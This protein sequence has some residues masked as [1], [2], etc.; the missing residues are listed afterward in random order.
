MKRTF[1]FAIILL[2]LVLLPSVGAQHTTIT[3]TSS[4][5]GTVKFTSNLDP[6]YS[7]V[8]FLSHFDGADGATTATEEKGHTITFNGDAQ[9][10]TAQ[11]KFGS[12]S[13]LLDGTGDSIQLADS[14][15]W[16]LGSGS[17]TIEGFVRFNN[18][19]ANSGNQV[20]VSQ[21]N[22][23][24]NQRAF[25]IRLTAGNQI[26]AF[27]SNTGASNSSIIGTASAGLQASWTPSNNVW[28]YIVLERDVDT[29]YIGIDTTQKATDTT[30]GQAVFNSTEALRF[31]CFNSSG[32]TQ[33]VNGWLDEWRITKGVARYHGTFSV[34]TAPFPNS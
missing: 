2:V 30:A 23:V 1:L 5:T 9:L 6:S 12:A 8:V 7:S 22:N 34:P 24:G 26:T 27:V 15:D 20:L 33:F 10:D 4:G 18:K 16:D 11:F 21:Y 28:Y 32:L 25:Y 17:F 13:L 14:S 31:G 29:W 19:D 3:G